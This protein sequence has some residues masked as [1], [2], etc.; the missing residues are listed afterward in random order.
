MINKEKTRN[1]LEAAVEAF[2]LPVPSLTGS[3]AAEFQ[4][5]LHCRYRFLG[6][7]EGPILFMVPCARSRPNP[8]LT[9][10]RQ[11]HLSVAAGD[12]QAGKFSWFQPDP[13]R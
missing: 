7:L 5:D 3:F 13:A 2:P 9:P 1:L 11:R 10:R 8:T 4:R 12:A 6:G